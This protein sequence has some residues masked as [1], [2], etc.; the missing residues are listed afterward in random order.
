[1]LRQGCICERPYWIFHSSHIFK[2]KPQSKNSHWLL[3]LGFI[4]VKKGSYPTYDVIFTKIMDLK[5]TVAQFIECL[6]RDR[7]I[8]NL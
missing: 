1:M 5:S 8:T 3:L 2:N 4:Q 6:S 7:R